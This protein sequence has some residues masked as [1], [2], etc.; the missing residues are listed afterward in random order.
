MKNS[1]LCSLV[2]AFLLSPIFLFASSVKIQTT[3]GTPVPGATVT[4]FDA[5]WQTLTE[6]NPGEFPLP[7]NVSPVIRVKVVLENMQFLDNTVSTAQ[8]YVVP[9]VTV[10]TI[11]LSSQGAGI[12]GAQVE[13]FLFGWHDHGVTNQS[14]V[15][16]REMLP[17]SY[18]FK[19]S[20][21]NGTESRFG[22]SVSNN[23]AGAMDVVFNTV[24][25]NTRLEDS[26]GQGIENGEVRTLKAGWLVHG[27]TDANGDQITEMLPGD[28]LFQ[29]RYKNGMD[30]KVAYSV[31]SGVQSH[32]LV[33]TTV[34][35]NTRLLSSQGAG[36]SG[37]TPYVHRGNWDT[38]GTTQNG[39]SETEM[40]PGKYTF[41]MEFYG[42]RL[43]TGFIT[44]LG[45]NTSQNVD[46]QTV[47][48]T[49]KLKESASAGGDPLPGAGVESF[50][51]EWIDQ[52]TT[53]S[54]GEVF[55]EMLEGKYVFRVTYNNG[56]KRDNTIQILGTNTS[57]QVLF[58]TVDV[59]VHLET[60]DGEGLAGGVVR[61]VN[62]GQEYH[63]VT[64]QDGISRRNMLPGKYNVLIQYNNGFDIKRRFDIQDETGAGR[65]DIYFNTTTTNVRVE[66]QTGDGIDGVG[67]RHWRSGWSAVDSTECGDR[68]TELLPGTYRIE[69]NYNGQ[70]QT[71]ASAVVS[72]ADMTVD[73]SYNDPNTPQVCPTEPDCVEDSIRYY[74]T[75][76]FRQNGSSS[77]AG[78]SIWIPDL[79]YQG[80]TARFRFDADAQTYGFF[81][82]TLDGSGARLHGIAQLY[83]GG[84][85][86]AG[87][88]KRD[89]T[90]SYWVID[91]PMIP[92]P[93]ATPKIEQGSHQP[94]SVTELWRYFEIVLRPNPGQNF[95]IAGVDCPLDCANLTQITG[96]GSNDLGVQAGYTANGK[97]LGYGLS[98]WFDWDAYIDKDGDSHCSNGTRTHSFGS[99]LHGDINV[100]LEYLP[101]FGE[102][103][104]GGV[105]YD[106]SNYNQGV[107][108]HGVWMPAYFA[109]GQ[110]ARFKWKQDSS[111]LDVYPDGTARAH[112]IAEVQ[113]GGPLGTEFY[114]NMKFEAPLPTTG[115]KIEKASIQPPELRDTW[116][117]FL[118]VEDSNIEMFE[119]FGNR[120]ADYSRRPSNGS[121]GLQIG[122]AANNKDSDF[123]AST[124]FYYDKYVNYDLTATSSRHGDLNVDLR[125]DCDERNFGNCVA[126][127][128]L[129]TNQGL[130]INGN[131]VPA[132]RS[133]WTK[134]LGP[135]QGGDA[136]GS[137]YS[138]GMGGD[139]VLHFG[140]PVANLSGNDIR[141][142]ETSYGNPSCN[143]YPEQAELFASQDGVNWFSLGVNCLDGEYDLGALD[144]A[145]YFRVLDV[146][147]SGYT[148]G[149]GDGFD[150]DAVEC[151]NG[152]YTG[153]SDSIAPLRISNFVFDPGHPVQDFEKLGTIRSVKSYPNPFSNQINLSYDIQGEAKVEIEI[154]DM[155]GN[156]L[157]T[158]E[159]GK[160]VSGASTST[161]EA[162]GTIIPGVYF[163]SIRANDEVHRGKILK[164]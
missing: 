32:T 38:L 163:Y 152:P 134:V 94:L 19:V 105:R 45:S 158:I 53:D 43:T 157:E 121:K 125:A 164:Q 36:L 95:H 52:G 63:P 25:V 160:V 100:D 13:T 135:P 61:S 86:P 98:T 41:R 126:T 108:D 70:K 69:T 73:F 84:V 3:S 24:A 113:T 154:L 136:V 17:G 12:S 75:S 72:G 96:G 141:L 99:S 1:G 107:N 9:T 58:E 48:V 47:G 27:Q 82:V 31:P 44:I 114:F 77:G 35:V 124:W 56:A 102:C 132:N 147:P 130:T 161:W 34:T 138:L 51:F 90:G 78:H 131:P 11:L 55:R 22:V 143:Q 21:Q 33:F 145:F 4:I 6:T 149:S 115:P 62:V 71:N 37:G 49:T 15:Q 116:E 76:A 106:M 20:Y 142:T 2:M 162:D 148:G 123:G 83:T 156:V 119:L 133:D 54:N 50:G 159:S 60:S 103:P 155:M 120:D 118:L 111:F 129:A 64:D 146:S 80:Q 104:P 112:G 97:N 151:L 140:A 150:I 10:R 28:F 40:L 92:K 65:A 26:D 46:F 117:Y 59:Y 87:S 16:S 109:S 128:V 91:I 7:A 5:G 23:P 85:P 57:Q 67:V 39:D 79:I 29:M 30:E 137:F 66:Y 110:T 89:F 153:N 122:A 144:W 74:V 101:C 8:D 68:I 18:R 42:G 127:E 93:G 81:D 14:G 139:I 88:G